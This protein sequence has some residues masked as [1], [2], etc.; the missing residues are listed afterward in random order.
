MP[1]ATSK[2]SQRCIPQRYTEGGVPTSG[3]LPNDTSQS[4]RTANQPALP[5]RPI[6]EGITVQ[7]G[8]VGPQPDPT[9]T[10][11]TGGPVTPGPNIPQGGQPIPAQV[12]PTHPTNPTVGPFQQVPMATPPVPPTWASHACPHSVIPP[13]PGF[14]PRPA[15]LP[16]PWC[17]Q[18]WMA[19]S[20]YHQPGP[21]YPIWP[22]PPLS[23]QI[24][25]AVNQV[26][27][28]PPAGMGPATIQPAWTGMTT[29]SAAATTTQ[30][31][32]PGPTMPAVIPHTFGESSPFSWFQQGCQGA[33]VNFPNFTG[34]SGTATVAS[35]VAGAGPSTLLD[36]G[37]PQKLKA[38]IVG[39]EYV[40][41]TK[42][43]KEL[44]NEVAYNIKVGESDEDVSLQLAKKKEPKSKIVTFNQW[45]DLFYKFMYI[46]M[47]S[48][49]HQAAQLL[50][51]SYTVRAIYKKGGDWLGYDK[52]FR[53]RKARLGLAWDSVCQLSYANA[54]IKNSNYTAGTTDKPVSSFST[55]NQPFRTSSSASV[56]TG[57][58]FRY[59]TAREGCPS[60]PCRW[61]HQCY[62]CHGSHKQSACTNQRSASPFQ[63]N[64]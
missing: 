35:S 51:H 63:R 39:G 2:R 56:P 28:A 18:Q 29:P 1:K 34:T 22:N 27:H 61:K 58:C 31:V 52:E 3:V 26:P 57:Y 13:P 48:L 41:L 43:D 12:Q 47:S 16:C 38:A 33:G 11:Q 23:Q 45:L 62:H 9:G 10:S 8:L 15:G 55:S 19:P 53:K 59:H 32:A 50:T 17:T 60:N 30:Q 21:F 4:N 42:L 36:E 6:E 54:V 24:G 49:P 7:D 46:H 64:L 20:Q 14:P 37:V 25:T 40:E 5:V 44:Y